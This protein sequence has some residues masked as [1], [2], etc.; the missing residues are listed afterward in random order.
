MKLNYTTSLLNKKVVLVP[1][2]IHHVEKYHEWMS[3]PVLQ[4]ATASEPLSIEEEYEM[5]QSW[6]N[7]ASKCTF[8][9]LSAIALTAVEP[10][11]SGEGGDEVGSMIGDVNLFLHDQE[12][13]TNAE[14]EI[15]IANKNYHR[16]G[17]AR[18]ALYL[19]M[20]YGI[21]HLGITRYFAKINKKNEASIS[22]FLKLGYNEVAYVAAFEEYEFELL[23]HPE[24][25]EQERNAILEVV[26]DCTHEDYHKMPFCRDAWKDV[27]KD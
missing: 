2:R 16:Q 17:C 8:I 18:E 6:K 26:N 3:D 1:Y 23:V 19:M 9:V 12:D 11:G 15:M 22:L 14:I 27:D 5:Q 24:K 13:P 25:N 21:K 20:M 7:D 4:E 10:G